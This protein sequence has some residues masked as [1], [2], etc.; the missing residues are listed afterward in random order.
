MDG[1]TD[2]W[3]MAGEF[4][5]EE[6]EDAGYTSAELPIQ[7]EVRALIAQA[8]A[9]GIDSESIMLDAHEAT[10]DATTEDYY[11]AAKSALTAAI[12]A[13]VQGGNRD[14]RQAPGSEGSTR[15]AGAAE[16][17]GN[18]ALE[19]T[20]PTAADITAQQDRAESAAQAEAA[21]KR[22]ADAAAAQDEDRKR[23]A[24][25]S[26]RAADTFELG[27]DPL[28]SLT[29]QVGMF[30]APAAAAQQKASHTRPICSP[31]GTR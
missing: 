9:L 11:E 30:D 18:P 25:A 2:Q 8:D 28:D 22:A 24:Q 31:C 17:T 12:E 15:E 6:L 5:T 23:I 10:R 27:Q 14:S 13:A 3:D 4:T 1:D 29:G 20:A 21:R 7:A 19:L 16:A 26:V